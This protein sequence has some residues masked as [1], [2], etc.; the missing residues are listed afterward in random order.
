MRRKAEGERRDKDNFLLLYFNLNV[1][2]LK[3]SRVEAF[4][5]SHDRT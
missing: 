5:H 1:Q 4:I 2:G 3:F